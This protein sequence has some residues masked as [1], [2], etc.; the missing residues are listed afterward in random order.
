MQL[1]D[2]S[3]REIAPLEDLVLRREIRFRILVV[4]VQV[5]RQAG[6]AVDRSS[7]ISS[8]AIA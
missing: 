8:R 1:P 6:T 4:G 2:D 3:P 5:V 7:L